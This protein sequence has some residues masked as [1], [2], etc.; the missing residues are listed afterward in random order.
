VL[1]GSQIIFAKSASVDAQNSKKLPVVRL[2]TRSVRYRTPSLKLNKTRTYQS[3]IYILGTAFIVT[4]K[5]DIKL[6]TDL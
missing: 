4:Y 6:W 2:R 1:H 5:I 3:I